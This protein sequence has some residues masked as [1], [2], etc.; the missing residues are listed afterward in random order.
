MTIEINYLTAIVL[1]GLL[2]GIGGVLWAGA[3]SLL[4]QYGNMVR[5][6]LADHRAESQQRQAGLASRLDDI[7]DTL[8]RHES[9]L[10]RLDAELAR[11]PTDEDLDR[12]YDRINSTCSDLAEVKGTLKVISENLRSIMARIAEKGLS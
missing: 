1:A 2:S 5:D 12:I 4:H 8:K 6:Q 11:V 9:N 7:E 3:R 10:V